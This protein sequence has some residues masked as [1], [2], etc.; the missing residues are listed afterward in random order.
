MRAAIDPGKH[1][2]S[3][4]VWSDNRLRS[5][6]LYQQPEELGIAIDLEFPDRLSPGTRLEDLLDLT[7]IA[8]GWECANRSCRRV[9]PSDWNSGNKKPIT[10]RKVWRALNGPEKLLAAK[11]IG[12]S[13]QAIE[14]K[15]VDA[16]NRLGRTGRVTRY[17]WKAHNI[18]DSIG[19]G[20]WS[21][22]RLL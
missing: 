4:S 3:V 20:L 10:H 7:A 9:K 5:V 2:S 14:D 16:C 19:I 17:A 22:G 13:E 18:L 1:F 15:I 12:M 6:A 21:H 11:A 8:G